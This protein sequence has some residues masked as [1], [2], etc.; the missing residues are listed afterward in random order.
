M[1]FRLRFLNHLLQWN[2]PHLNR[3]DRIVIREALKYCINYIRNKK[4]FRNIYL[5]IRN[6]KLIK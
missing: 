3:I 1:I 6:P 4:K 5:G 2:F